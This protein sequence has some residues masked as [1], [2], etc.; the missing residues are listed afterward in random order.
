MDSLGDLG[1]LLGNLKALQKSL[2]P[3]LNV[4]EHVPPIVLETKNLVEPGSQIYVR[5]WGLVQSSLYVLHNLARAAANRHFF[6]NADA[7]RVLH[8]YAGSDVIGRYLPA[9]LALSYVVETENE[10][11]LIK[12]EREVITTITNELG[13]IVSGSNTGFSLEELLEGLENL[14]MNQ[15]NKEKIATMAVPVLV[16]IMEKSYK[17]ET[18]T[19]VGF[20]SS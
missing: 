12:D 13:K 15:E 1:S 3:R 6:N 19:S 4:N 11:D 8:I 16:Q 9:M 18:L 17:H 2:A 5:R 14:S 10:L 20:L 7:K